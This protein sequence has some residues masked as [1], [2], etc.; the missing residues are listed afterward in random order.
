MELEDLSTRLIEAQARVSVL[1]SS[2]KSK[3]K[4]LKTLVKYKDQLIKA[5]WVLAQVIRLTQNRFKKKVENLVT[6]AVKAVFVDRNFTFELDF[7]T[8]KRSKFEVLPIIKEDGETF[9]PKD[10]M[11]GSLVDIIS[12]ALRVVLWRLQKPQS[13]AVF[14]LDEP[15]RNLGSG[16]ELIL[17]A[18]FISQL[19][20]NKKMPIQFIIVT[21]EEEIIGVSDRAWMVTYENG[22]SV[23]KLVKGKIKQKKRKL[24]RRVT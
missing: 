24:K 2:V 22:R 6:M 10:D 9:T 7:R 16:E 13:R 17:G 20:H 14:L 3:E 12:I 18:K 11:G 1:K 23:V 21:H 15:F 4:E 8:D 19:S 5:Q